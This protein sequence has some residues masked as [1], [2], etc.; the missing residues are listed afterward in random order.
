[1]G[2]EPDLTGHGGCV[3]ST[4][5]DKDAHTHEGQPGWWRFEGEET[6]PVWSESAS[7]YYALPRPGIEAA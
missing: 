3:P 1:M 6:G 5:A 7:C 2:S 4:S